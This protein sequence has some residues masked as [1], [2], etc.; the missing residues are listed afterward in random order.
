MS[1]HRLLPFPLFALLVCVSACD[2]GSVDRPTST[3]TPTRTFTETSTPTVTRTR[4]PVPTATGVP[5]ATAT[6]TPPE[7]TATASPIPPSATAT[8]SPVPTRTPTQASDVLQIRVGRAFVDAG[9]TAL[10]DVALSTGGKDVGGLQNDLLFDNTIVQL[11]AASRCRINPAIGDRL[12]NCQGDPGSITEPCKTL[13]RNLVQCGSFPQPSGCPENARGNISRF[14]GIVAAT[15]VPNSVPIPST[16][17][18]T[19]EFNVVDRARLPQ[20]ILNTSFIAADPRGNRLPDLTGTNGLITISARVA[21]TAFG[22]ARSLLVYVEDANG[23]PTS[24]TMQILNQAVAFTRSS[25]TLNLADELAET[26]PA[27]TVI[28]LTF[29]A[30]TPTPTSTQGAATATPSQVVEPSATPTEVVEPSATPTEIV[31]PTATPI[32]ASATPTMTATPPPSSTPTEPPPATATN[33]PTATESP[34]PT[35]TATEAVPATATVTVSPSPSSTPSVTLTP[36]VTATPTATPSATATV[37]P[38]VQIL[39]SSAQPVAGVVDIDIVLDAEVDNVGGVQNDLLFDSNVVNLAS[40]SECRINPAIGD[41]LPNCEEDPELITAPCKTLSRLLVNC[42]GSPQPSGCPAGAGSN[43][44]RFRG[45]IGAT[46][47][48]NRNAIPD[49]VLYTCTFTVV[50]PAG[51]PATIDVSRPV[52]SDPR[53]ERLEPVGSLDGIVFAP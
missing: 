47:V 14:R 50:N 21:A 26:V 32:P 52:A 40:A 37:P 31:L 11:S 44:R 5:S 25:A 15:A 24:G 20:A 34:V 29:G 38:I 8:A 30:P 1:L 13:N 48:P 2:N 27:D 23:L 49:G 18:Y 35:P 43:I 7:P 9:A 19:C 53:G 22:G 16:V 10:I 36:S 28:W 45:V 6:L 4:T 17:V 41:R 51:L 12:D 3:A 46:A 39:A 33:S 42:G